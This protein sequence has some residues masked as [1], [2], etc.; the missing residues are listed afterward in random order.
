MSGFHRQTDSCY[1]SPL[2][3]LILLAEACPL[4]PSFH[5]GFESP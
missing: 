2:V 4:L 1:R 5:L 3:L